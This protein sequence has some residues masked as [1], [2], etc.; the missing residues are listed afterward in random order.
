MQAKQKDSD[1]WTYLIASLRGTLSH[2]SPPP[3]SALR[4]KIYGL[5]GWLNQYS[6]C[7]CTSLRIRITSTH[8][9]DGHGDVCI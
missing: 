6:I 3:Q 5:W 4:K 2:F 8:I 7:P 1:I 9:E